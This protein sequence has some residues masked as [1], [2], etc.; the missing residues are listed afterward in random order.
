MYPSLYIQRKSGFINS[1]TITHDETG[2]RFEKGSI[3]PTM[4]VNIPTTAHL[5]FLPSFNQQPYNPLFL[6]TSIERITMNVCTHCVH[7][8]VYEI[9]T[10]IYAYLSINDATNL[11][12]EGEWN[13]RYLRIKSGETTRKLD[14]IAARAMQIALCSWCCSVRF[15][16]SR[17]CVF[18][19]S[20]KESPRNRE[21][22][23]D[24]QPLERPLPI[25]LRI[26]R[27]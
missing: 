12:D 7:F 2:A 13:C 11:E 18:Y 15:S 8:C 17:S 16:F 19:A 5:S 3:A 22:A 1:S 9:H 4:L 25:H 21:K 24:K 26:L 20:P 10:H 23:L 14:D 6:F 27:K